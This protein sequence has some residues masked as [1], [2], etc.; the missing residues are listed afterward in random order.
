MKRNL[1][2][3]ECAGLLATAGVSAATGLER[4]LD[5]DDSGDDNEGRRTAQFAALSRNPADP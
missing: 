2:L 3:S 1:E 5:D 4:D